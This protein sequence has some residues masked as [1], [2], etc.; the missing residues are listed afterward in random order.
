M[1][2]K[3]ICEEKEASSSKDS[4]N[5]PRELNG[6]VLN[7]KMSLSRKKGRGTSKCFSLE[8]GERAEKKKKHFPHPERR[9]VP[10]G[11]DSHAHGISG[12]SEGAG[13]R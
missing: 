6:R 10:V 4:I 3:K 8:R 1:L 2:E 13:R 11:K 7:W 12:D 5:L 9:A